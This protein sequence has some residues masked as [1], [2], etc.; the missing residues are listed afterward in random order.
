MHHVFLVEELLREILDYLGGRTPPENLARLARTCKYLHLPCVRVL[1]S[2]LR[3]ISPLVRL[4]PSDAWEIEYNVTHY[5]F[6][7]A[8]PAGF[9]SDFHLSL[10]CLSC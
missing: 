7:N 2:R 1:W 4:L 3:N 6:A 8:V 9:V 10:A 5:E